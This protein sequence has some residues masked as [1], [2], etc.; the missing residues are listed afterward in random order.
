[1]VGPQVTLSLSVSEE[2][3]ACSG[4]CTSRLFFQKGERVG[5]AGEL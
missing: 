4:L 1:M 3:A 5:N 2:G